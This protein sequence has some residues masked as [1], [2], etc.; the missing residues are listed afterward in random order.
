LKTDVNTD[1]ADTRLLVR[2]NGNHDS[3]QKRID[4]AISIFLKNVEEVPKLEEQ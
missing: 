3:H 2:K 4:D 1:N